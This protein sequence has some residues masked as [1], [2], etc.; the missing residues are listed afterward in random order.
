MNK[1]LSQAITEYGQARLVR[2]AGLSRAMVS[3]VVSGQRSFG[4]RKAVI[5]ASLLDIPLTVVLG[6]E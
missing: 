1:T 6:I 3:L 5:I 2:D 4:K